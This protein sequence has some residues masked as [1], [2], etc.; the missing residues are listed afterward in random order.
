MSLDMKDN[1]E[2]GVYVVYD[3][4]GVTYLPHFEIPAYVRPGFYDGDPL[5]RPIYAHKNTY[6][7]EE[8]INAGAKER[9]E[10]L[11]KRV[12]DYGAAR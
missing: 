1:V 6:Q 7:K 10:M 5:R 2:K 8:L 11:W 4:D 3:L 9:Y 12:K